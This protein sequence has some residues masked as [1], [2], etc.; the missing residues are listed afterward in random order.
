MSVK[1][2]Y[3]FFPYMVAQL[4]LH[5]DDLSSGGEWLTKLEGTVAVGV[6]AALQVWFLSHY[7]S[8]CLYC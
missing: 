2:Q 8:V 7:S 5:L 4:E 1:F 3:R 6:V